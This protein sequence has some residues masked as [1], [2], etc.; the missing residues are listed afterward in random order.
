MQN[1]NHAEEQ[2]HAQMESIAQMVAALDVD[3][4]R[5]EE[6]RELTK[7]PRYFA[8]WNMPGYMPDNPPAAF[9][10]IDDACAYIADAMESE[11]DDIEPDDEIPDDADPDQAA[12]ARETA[13]SLRQAA[14][15]QRQ[16]GNSEYGQTIGR[17]HYFVTQDGFMIDEDPAQREELA[18]LE[19]SAGDCED[20][21]DAQQRISE[22][23]L[24]VEYRSGWS[25]D[26]HS[27]EPDEFCVLLCTGGPAVRIVGELGDH[28][29]IHRA[30]L[31]YQDWG[32]PWTHYYDG[33]SQTLISY[34]ES[35]GVGQF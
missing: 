24:S 9:D 11:A 35:L 16:Y 31:E 21:D 34:C 25:S 28:G 10:D 8:G 26:P 13:R 32:T 7:T 14:A 15:R 22:D 6:L 29:A 19:E 3:Y 12:A 20:E 27:L 1:E 4:G 23:P 18:D 17:F 33:D 2:A 5:L 30:W